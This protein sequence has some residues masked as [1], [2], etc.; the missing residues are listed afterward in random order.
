MFVCSL[1]LYRKTG[2][3]FITSYPYDKLLGCKCPSTDASAGLPYSFVCNP[4]YLDAAATGTCY[5]DSDCGFCATPFYGPYIAG[6]VAAFTTLLTL[7][8]AIGVSCVLKPVAPKYKS[9]DYMMEVEL[10]GAGGY[11]YPLYVKMSERQSI[12]LQNYLYKLQKTRPELFSTMT[13]NSGGLMH[14]LNSRCFA[15]LVSLFIASCIIVI[16]MKAAFIMTEIR[17]ADIVWQQP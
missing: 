10:T 9:K 3:S 14:F 4:L 8:A 5:A 13:F 6:L 12:D 1:I 2:S 16:C 11:G 7:L 15:W 17:A